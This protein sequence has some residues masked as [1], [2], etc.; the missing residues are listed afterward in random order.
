MKLKKKSGLISAVIALS[1]ASLVSV[2][3]ASWVISQGD[4][5][6][7]SGTIVV[8]NVENRIH[9]IDD[10]NSGWLTALDGTIDNTK[11]KIVYG[12][13]QA[14]LDS[15]GWLQNDGKLQG[16]NSESSLAVLTA[17]YKI[18]IDNVSATDKYSDIIQSVTFAE[19]AAYQ[20]IR[21]AGYVGT[22]PTPAPYIGGVAADANTLVGT[23]GEI[24][25]VFEFHW[26]ATYDPD[27][28]VYWISDA[29]LTAN[30][31]DETARRTAAFEWFN[32][33]DEA[34]TTSITYNLSIVTK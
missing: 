11:N 9:T 5:A 34:L 20:T 2:G 8:D 14:A 12:A 28:Y 3:F 10:A 13:S 22:F 21:T 32:G 15:D 26:A 6:I 29:A 25:Y 1:C 27:P 17:W 7:E 30:G 23:T 24:V 31:G 4:E 18:K 19:P 16:D 33:L